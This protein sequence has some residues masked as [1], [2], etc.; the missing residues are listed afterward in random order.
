M[1]IVAELKRLTGAG[2]AA[3]VTVGV[4]GVWVGEGAAV[5]SVDAGSG[6]PDEVWAAD[7]AE[8]WTGATVA[9]EALAGGV[10]GVSSANE[11]S[12]WICFCDVGDCWG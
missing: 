12:S 11:A 4:A 5:D 2:E 7:S 6:V 8:S 3:A 1:V 10:D 9:V